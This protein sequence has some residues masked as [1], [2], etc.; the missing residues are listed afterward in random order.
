ML[1]RLIRRAAALLVCA[2]CGVWGCGTTG[3]DPIL[4]PE[5]RFDVLPSG[6][7]TF[8][9]DAL[10]GGG[11]SY[12]SVIGQQFTA[13]APFHFA[14]E[15]AGQPLMGAFS[16]NPTSGDQI[17]VTLTVIS[18]LSQTQVSDAT[19]P[20]KPTARVSIPTTA[21][22][23]TPPPGNPEVRFDVCAPLPGRTTCSAT[24]GNGT[25]GAL[26]TGSFGD[27]FISYLTNGAT[28][29]IYFYRAP[30][31]NINAVLT[32]LPVTGALLAVQL[33]VN[34]ELKQ[35]EVGSGEVII[36]QDL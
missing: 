14:L 13:T 23:V 2:V 7:A 19:G 9:V 35:T 4:F 28:P 26:F 5:V 24:T 31:S 30:Q 12:A 15:N 21:A 22:G 3:S 10:S 27:P 11:E 8:T 32:R 25:F 6:Q 18:G 36:S 17:T 16:V 20:G 29:T 34:G 1:Q 33:L